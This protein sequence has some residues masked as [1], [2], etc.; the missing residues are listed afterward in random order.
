MA[1]LALSAA[2]HRVGIATT[3]V[4]RHP[5]PRPGGQAVDVRGPARTVVE[6]LGLGPAVAA[7]RLQ[8]RGYAVVDAR[9]RVLAALPVEAFGGNGIVS[10]TELLRG[11]L[12]DVLRS[13]VPATTEFLFD[14]TVTAIDAGP[15]GVDVRLARG[16]S[17]RV[18]LVVGADG[19][20]SAVRR[21]AFGPEEGFAH[22]IG[23]GIAW[24][25]ARGDHGLDGWFRAHPSP[26]GLLASARPGRLP[27]E[28]RAALAFRAP[29]WPAARQGRDAVL[30]D[31]ARRFAGVG[32]LA[33]DLLAAAGV[34]DDLA[35]EEMTQVRVPRWS[36]GRVA[37]L[38]DAAWCS[39]PLTGMGTSMA[40]VGAHVLAHR[41]ATTPPRQWGDVALPGYQDDLGAWVARRRRL[42]P[43]GR[44]GYVPCS[45]FRIRAGALSLRAMTRWPLEPLAARMFSDADDLALP[46][47]TC[48]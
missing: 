6:H 30:A 14:D 17:R 38:G 35:T 13:A 15:A 24:F 28:V 18:D 7:V 2:L 25:T 11:D 9:G 45:A 12:V 42:P 44:D 26:G 48:P 4:E 33:A 22:P 23:V 37:L 8:Q 16:G 32:W 3:V 19:V 46:A 36:R 20:H 31:L 41:L 39:T 1:G 34:A 5:G 40:L 29:D 47:L 21:L 10:E 27:G 43:G